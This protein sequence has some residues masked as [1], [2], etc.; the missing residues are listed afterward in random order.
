M[1]REKEQISAIV[2]DYQRQFSEAQDKRAQDFTATAQ[3]AQQ[4]FT[5]VTAEY[6]SQ[7]STGQD[8]RQKEFSEALKATERAFKDTVAL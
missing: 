1:Q 7:F 8:S 2:V 6:Q 4:E 3:T 5:R